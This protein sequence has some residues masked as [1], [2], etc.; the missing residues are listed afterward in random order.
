MPRAAVREGLAGLE[1]AAA[2]A[3]GWSKLAHHIKEAAANLELAHVSGAVAS[4]ETAARKGHAGR[5]GAGA[6]PEALADLRAGL[7]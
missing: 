3:R 2:A 7:A 1:R 6:D 5:A 4:I